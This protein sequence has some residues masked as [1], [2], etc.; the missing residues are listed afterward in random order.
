MTTPDAVL[1]AFLRAA[2]VPREDGHTTG[3]LDEAE[4]IRGAHPWL[5]S[6]SVLAAAALGDHAALASALAFDP[7]AAT[8]PA[9]PYGW[10]PLT[11]LCFSRYLRLDRTRADDFTRSAALL[12]EAGA[13]P[14]TGWWSSAH[15]PHPVHER[16]LYGA[17]AIARHADV[18]ALLLSHGA[19]PNDE[20]TPY[21]VP[22]SYDLDTL[23]VLLD[24]GRCT[25]ETLSTMLLRKSDWHDQHGSALL[26]ARGADPN[27]VTR[28][29]VTALQQAVRRDNA[30]EQLRLLL[31]HGAD[32]TRGTHG[33]DSI[34]LAA[35][36]GRGDLL[37]LLRGRGVPLPTEGR[38]ALLIACASDDGAA[39]DRLMRDD[40]RAV[41][42]VQAGGGALLC[43]FA[44][45]GNAAGVAHLLQVGIAANARG[46]ADG[47]WG[48]AS[49]VTA[50]HVAAWRLR[51]D[52]VALLLASGASV[53][54][55][56]DR[57]Q[58]AM[59]YYVRG[60][61]SSYWQERRTPVIGAALLAVGASVADIDLPTG[62]DALDALLSR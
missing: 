2:S 15:E 36:R 37:D 1:S 47:Y 13:N 34:T 61:T 57:G 29:G 35:E 18:T 16:V 23:T 55:T 19:D 28:W 46:P 48:L 4:A 43:A 27:A 51:D 30:I 24:S 59:Q 56:D 41:S 3:A 8:R 5:T 50:L 33:V 38:T 31:D 6:A 44:G 45:V 14:N 26:L 53:E 17:A 42:A 62:Y 49:G 40:S 11:Q 7:G 32:A 21:H 60:C 52:V 54:L 20:E 10:D 12:L 39:V 9:E 58:T 25:P 22:E